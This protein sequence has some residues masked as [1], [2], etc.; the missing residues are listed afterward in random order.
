MQRGC[1]AACT[2]CMNWGALGSVHL[3]FF[4][5]TARSSVGCSAKKTF[6]GYQSL[7]DLCYEAAFQYLRSSNSPTQRY[8]KALWSF[9]TCFILW[10]FV[11]WVFNL[12][13]PFKGAGGFLRPYKRYISYHSYCHRKA[14]T[15]KSGCFQHSFK[16]LVQVTEL[17]LHPLARYNLSKW[18]HGFFYSE[19]TTLRTAT[20][21]AI[22]HHQWLFNTL[23]YG[24]LSVI[25]F[26]Q[27]I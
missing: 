3:H 19:T 23:A 25:F 17:W 24:F 9:A 22:E 13:R 10:T 14:L 4:I 5:I 15:K 2:D 1:G 11:W 12:F 21:I 18:S 16:C 20:S 7:V 8:L 26:C 27:L 6:C